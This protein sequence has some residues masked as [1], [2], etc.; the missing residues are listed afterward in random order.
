MT[1]NFEDFVIKTVNN[2]SNFDN[3]NMDCIK[4]VVKEAIA[5]YKLKSYEEIEETKSGAVKI[6][7]IHSMAEENLLSKVVQS[8][9]KGDNTYNVEAVYEGRVVREY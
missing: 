8:A 4:Q 1:I 9:I 5:C 6:L 2:I 7:H 3:E